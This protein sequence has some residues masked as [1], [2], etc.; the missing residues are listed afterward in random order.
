MLPRLQRE[1]EPFTHPLPVVRC[2]S[3][4][5]V[6]LEASFLRHS[7]AAV[8]QAFFHILAGPSESRQLEV[9]DCRSTIHCDVA[10]YS[11]GEPGLDEG[12]EPHFDNMSAEEQDY[13]PPVT[14]GLCDCLNQSAKIARGEYVREAREERCEGTV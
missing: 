12:T 10:D 9:M 11:L 13:G 3:D 14:T 7:E 6:H 5:P 4:S 2:R 8:G 1:R